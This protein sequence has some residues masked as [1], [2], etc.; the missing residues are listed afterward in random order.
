MRQNGFVWLDGNTSGYRKWGTLSGI[1]PTQNANTNCVR[2]RY[3]D[4]ASELSQGWVNAV[5]S[6]TRNCYFCS[7]SGK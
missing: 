2:H 7:K 4:S 6:D 5:C 1:H 3:R